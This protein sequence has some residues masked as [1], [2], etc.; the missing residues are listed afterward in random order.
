MKLYFINI[1]FLIIC[2]F[3]TV[4]ADWISGPGALH[5]LRGTT[6]GE[7]VLC[8]VS[9]GPG[10]M[11]TVS[12]QCSFPKSV[13]IELCNKHPNC[14]GLTC[15]PSRADCQ[16]RGLYEARIGQDTSGHWGSFTYYRKIAGVS[17]PQ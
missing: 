4:H 15:N 16:A 3:P 12:G 17:N 6:P 5:C 9:S 10:C 13:A 8:E 7:A 1:L 11:A 14:Y 2:A